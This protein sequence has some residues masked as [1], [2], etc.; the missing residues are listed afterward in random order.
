MQIEASNIG[1]EYTIQV[2]ESA[3]ELKSRQLTHQV[4]YNSLTLVIGIVVGLLLSK[5]YRFTVLKWFN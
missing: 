5:F 4:M 2:L 3:L 1:C